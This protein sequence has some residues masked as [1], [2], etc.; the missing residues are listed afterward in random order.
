[1]KARLRSQGGDLRRFIKA[2]LDGDAATLEREIQAFAR[3]MLSY[4]DTGGNPEA[5]YHGFVLG[6]LGILEPG[7]LV[8]SNRESGKGRPDVLITPRM[9]GQPGAVL[10]LKIA[11]PGKKTLD[12][13]LDEGAAQL[14]K[15]EYKGELSAVGADPIHALVIAFDG[16]D[17]RVRNLDEPAGE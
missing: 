15:K 8:R 16:K 11:Q 6:L 17:V 9:P 12:Q 1:M 5:L 14:I 3:A 7:H 13:A 4:H 10:E 2:L